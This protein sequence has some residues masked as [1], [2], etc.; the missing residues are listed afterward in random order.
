[1]SVV[2]DRLKEYLSHRD[3]SVSRAES[4][5]EVSNG[6]L[7]KPF[8]KGTTIKIDTLEKFL[9][10]FDDLNPLWLF[11][12][13]EKAK[14]IIDKTKVLNEASVRTNVPKVVTVDTEGNEN[15]LMV[16]IPAQAGYLNGIGDPEYLESLPSYRLPRLN[17]G[18]FRMFEVKGHSMFPT[19]HAGAIAVGEFCESWKGDI[20]DNKIYIVITKEDGIVIKRVLNRLEK[21]GNLFLKS[22]NRK[23]YPSYPVKIEDIVEVWELKTA[24]IFDFQDPADL[25]DRVSDMEVELLHMKALLPSKNK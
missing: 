22:D 12:T 19:I 3:I 11:R 16:P 18:T 24:F 1:M 14:M 7:S 2:I 21:Y 10:C 6:T 17:N 8:K 15:I 4:M 23:E 5:I 20:K 25:Y 9:N 13:S